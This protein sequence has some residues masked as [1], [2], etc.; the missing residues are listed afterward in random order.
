ME[1]FKLGLQQNLKIELLNKGNLY[2]PYFHPTRYLDKYIIY[3]MTKG[4]L[5]L[6]L[7]GEKLE[8]KEG[9]IFFFKKGDFHKPVGTSTCSY[10]YIHFD[11]DFFEE[12]NL[13]EEEYLNFIEQKRMTSLKTDHR[14]IDVYNQFFV[15][16]KR[17]YSISNKANYDYIKSLLKANTI[18]PISRFPENRVLASAIVA[19]MLFLLEY[20]DIETDEHSKYL[21]AKNIASFVEVNYKTIESSYDIEKEFNLNFDYLNRV[22]KSVMNIS[23]MKYRNVVRINAAKEMLKTSDLSIT[24][25]ANDVGFSDIYYFSRA[26][27][28]Q[29]GIAPSEY[30]ISFRCE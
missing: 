19:K 26:F 2:S 14:D 24:Q 30:K 4:V 5:N 11:T 10:Y 3:V 16:L 13:A 15:L 27:K 20:S 23:I 1:C 25:I 22:F 29:E 21:Y 12:I 17:K 18:S 8:L 28:K 7:N 9:D 6:E